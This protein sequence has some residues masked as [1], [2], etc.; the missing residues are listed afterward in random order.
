M[1]S[2]AS[3][4]DR[5]VRPDC[6]EDFAVFDHFRANRKMI[7]TPDR[8][9]RS[10]STQGGFLTSGFRGMLAGLERM[11]IVGRTTAGKEELR[12]RGWH[13]NGDHILPRGVGVERDQRGQAHR[14]P[15]NGSTK[16][17]MRAGFGGRSNCCWRARATTP[18]RRL[19]AAIGPTK[20]FAARCSTPSGTACEHFRQPPTAKSQWSAASSPKRKR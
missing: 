18:S 11:L 6:F 2:C 10:H 8:D 5:L 1:A 4:L 19:S 7:W 12:K 14:R 16:S 9:G 20:G 13:P 17:R 15:G 3:N